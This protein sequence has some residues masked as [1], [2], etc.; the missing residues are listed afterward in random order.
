LDRYAKSDL[1]DW[2][3]AALEAT[4]AA[5]SD[6]SRRQSAAL[7]V[8][9]G[10]TTGKPWADRKFDLRIEDHPQPIDEL[11]RLVRLQRA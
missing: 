9:S 8:V 7:L 1:A 3:I 4:E 6:I 10:Q 2:L 5:S 11:K